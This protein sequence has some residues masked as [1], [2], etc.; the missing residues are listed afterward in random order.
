MD[1]N[2]FK[3]NLKKMVASGDISSEEAERLLSDVL[4][5]ISRI[6]QNIDSVQKSVKQKMHMRARKVNGTLKL[7]L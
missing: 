7:P 3:E 2:E 5:N 4:E 1:I 6:K